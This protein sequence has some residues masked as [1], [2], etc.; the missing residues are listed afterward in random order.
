MSRVDYTAKLLATENISVT[1]RGTRTAAFDVVNR[2]LYLPAWKDMSKDLYDLMI[3]HEVGHALFT[4]SEGWHES[5]KEFDFPR[6]FINVIEDIRIERMVQDKYPGLKASF[7][8]GY[9]ELVDRD[10]FGTLKRPMITFGF[11]DRLN[12]KSKVR[13]LIDVPFTEEELVYVKKAASVQTF[14]DVIKVC[15]EIYEWLQE[16]QEDE[17]QCI[18]TG[19]SQGG[20]SDPTDEHQDFSGNAPSI[21]NDKEKDSAE[22][23]GP[24]STGPRGESGETKT[25]DSTP[26]PETSG[27]NTEDSDEDT[28]SDVKPEE[29]EAG[30]GAPQAPEPPKAVE[31]NKSIDEV[32]TDDTYRDKQEELLDFDDKGRL[33]V[34]CEGLS[35][36]EVA[37]LIVPTSTVVA[38]RKEHLNRVLEENDYIDFEAVENSYKDFVNETNKVV[39]TMAKEFEMRKAAYQL[40]RAKESKSGTLDVTKLH[41]YK[42]TEDLF[43]RNTQ[44]GDAKSHGIVSFIDFSGSMH[45]VINNV[46]HQ[47]IVLAMFCRKVGVPFDIYS[48]TTPSVPV[49]EKGYTKTQEGHID[50]RSASLIHQLSS[51]MKKGEFTEAVKSL[52]YAFSSISA[53]SYRTYMP[54][55]SAYDHLGGTPLNESLIAAH[56]ILADFKKKNGVQKVSLVTITDGDGS[57]LEVS[58]HSRYFDG[59]LKV[60][61]GKKFVG[62]GYGY[63]R[64]ATRSLLKSLSKEGYNTINYFIV[65]KARDIKYRMYGAQMANKIPEYQKMFRR[66]KIVGMPKGF[67]GYDT[68]FFIDGRQDASDDEFEVSDNAKKGEITRAF[69]KFTKSKKTN[70]AMAVKFAEAIA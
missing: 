28:G 69:K 35:N 7:K 63:G 24:T 17:K 22:T 49:C 55:A 12:I 27:D 9:K 60:R 47:A 44:I 62:V 25:D 2:V 39:N 68:Y 18:G 50:L 31:E 1:Q 8:R 42:F 23:D 65:E 34:Y 43:L 37:N 54:F 29:G 67:G 15:A 6:A 51:R 14:E 48:F 21:N 64:D 52:Y 5:D 59:E 30:K 26:S 20:N 4:P 58:G 56:T 36:Q 46:V 3:G 19:A 38:A 11:M 10:F 32:E 45:G 40:A 53:Y 66:D 70:R 33:P 16:K 57:S 41:A 61:V 13:D